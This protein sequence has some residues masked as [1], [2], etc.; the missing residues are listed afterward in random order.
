MPDGE[1]YTPIPKIVPNDFSVGEYVLIYGLGGLYAGSHKA[2][3]KKINKNS[4]TVNLYH[5]VIDP[6]FDIDSGY[7]FIPLIPVMWTDQ[8]MESKVIHNLKKIEK[9]DINSRK[10]IQGYAPKQIL[11]L[12]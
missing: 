2:T 7:Y 6:D 10:L 8:I 5:Y 11:G 12:V 4:I 3:V 9:V 1:W